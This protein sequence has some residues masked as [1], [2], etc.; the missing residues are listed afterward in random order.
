MYKPSPIKTEL[1]EDDFDI[2]NMSSPYIFLKI[3]KFMTLFDSYEVI[4][5]YGYESIDD[6][7]PKNQIPIRR[8]EALDRYL[9]TLRITISNAKFIIK[10]KDTLDKLGVK[11][12]LLYKQLD[13]ATTTKRDGITKCEMIYINEEIFTKIIKYSREIYESLC[14]YMNQAGLIFKKREGFDVENI[15]DQFINLA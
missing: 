5:K 9:T 13:N 10:D 11:I 15:K 14:I 6:I 12:D 3:F 2:Y 1:S 7:V 8:K 4:A